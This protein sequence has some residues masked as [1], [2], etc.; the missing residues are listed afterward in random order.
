[1]DGGRHA[2]LAHQL[3]GE[4][5]AA[6]DARGRGARAE[7]AQA[8]GLERVHEARDQRRLGA[9]DVRSALLLRARRT[10][11][12]TSSAADVEAA[13][14]GGDAGVA[15]R[16]QHLRRARAAQQRAHDRVLAPAAADDQHARSRR[17][18]VRCY[19]T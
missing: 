15:G 13:R 10:S 14:V 19:A 17:H 8:L 18:C 16:A 6:L 2:G 4:R 12:S 5:L 9:D 7:R 3:L 11:P 1:M